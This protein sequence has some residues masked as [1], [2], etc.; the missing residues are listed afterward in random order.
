M[1]HDAA[2]RPVDC[3]STAPAARAR[4]SPPLGFC[5]NTPTESAEQQIH[6]STRMTTDVID[7]QQRA[8]VLGALVL[9]VYSLSIH[10]SS[11][12]R[13]VRRSTSMSLRDRPIA[14]ICLQLG[15]EAPIFSGGLIVAGWWRRW[16]DDLLRRHHLL[17]PQQQQQLNLG[18][19]R[20]IDVDQIVL[21][22]CRFV[23]NGAVVG[24]LVR[25]VLG[26]AIPDTLHRWT[27]LSL[28]DG[29][30]EQALD[31][32]A[33]KPDGGSQPG[34]GRWHA[35][36]GPGLAFEQNTTPNPT[37]G[38]VKDERSYS[39]RDGKKTIHNDL[40]A[41]LQ[42]RTTTLLTCGYPSVLLLRPWQRRRSLGH[43]V[44]AAAALIPCYSFRRRLDWPCRRC[45]AR[46]S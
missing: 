7:R 42:I 3:P 33:S 45:R 31:E 20:L 46:P 9:V 34:A 28:V 27:L 5:R 23:K 13:A 16:G 44:L 21:I 6:R 30:L 12:H 17:P 32:M 25:L 39:Y 18:R 35:T 36:P 24:L 29:F 14:A 4:W 10:S 40:L 43:V 19:L 1:T 11:I 26:P 15:G 37:V 38:V 22:I 41:P 2:G 8:K